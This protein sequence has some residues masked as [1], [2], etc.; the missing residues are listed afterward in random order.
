MKK[1]CRILI[2]ILAIFL[3]A[4]CDENSVSW[5]VK[6][7]DP[8]IM[9]RSIKQITDVIVHD[10]FSPPVAARIYAYV[11]VAGYEAGVPG[12]KR[13]QSLAGQLNGL[14]AVPQPDP[15]LEY[16]YRLASV[17][18]MLKVAKVLVFSEEKIESF[19][20]E[21]LLQF[22]EMGMPEDVYDRSIE[23]G[24]KVAEHVVSW[25]EADNYKQTR[26]F[27]KY[28]IVDD[29]STWKPTPPAYMDAVEP[30]WNEL[31]TFVIDSAT[32]FTPVP[33]TQ[34]AIVEGTRFF[35][36]ALEV[37][38]IGKNLSEEQREIAFFWDCNPFMLNVKGHVM[39]ATKKISPG[40]HWMNIAHVAC[41]KANADFQ[42]SAEAYALVSLSLID[43]FISCWDEKYR[44]R[45]VRPETYINQYIDEDWV[46]ILQ[47]PPFPEYTSGHSVISGSAAVALTNLFGDNFSFVDSTE[48]EFGMNSRSFN[49]FYHASEEAAVSRL[50][51]GIHY[52][53]AI[54][55]GVTQGKSI[56][57][58][59][60]EKISTRV[61]QNVKAKIQ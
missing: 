9:H 12:D 18:A 15:G 39:F 60:H 54:D 45:L 17:H 42:E 59:I 16:C 23:Y 10:I 51:G 31:R 49:S 41:K 32:Q 58:F 55:N 14:T 43:G 34:F 11:S 3:F 20:D 7:G 47:T 44:S 52:R 21:I 19:H 13:F 33:P 56:G 2:Q 24:S 61:L 1:I 57:E 22:K 37:Y 38:T 28:S 8:E 40:G 35:D 6:T 26:S 25:S 4:A 53:P 30:H 50:Y 27:P 36:E 48:I 5:Q 29:P 46:P